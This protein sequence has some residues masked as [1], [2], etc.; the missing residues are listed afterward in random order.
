MKVRVAVAAA[1]AITAV[2]GA[3]GASAATA[4]KLVVDDEGDAQ[5][6]TTATPSNDSL[7]IVSADVAT[8][9]KSITTV[10]R[11]KKYAATDVVWAM[12]RTYYFNFRIPKYDNA[13]YLYAGTFPEGTEFGFGWLDESMTPSSLRTVGKATGVFDEA[14]SEIRV[15]AVL[16][17]FPKA[18][19]PAVPRGTKLSG[20]KPEA[21][22]YTGQNAVKRPDGLP[23][24]VPFYRGFVW[25]VDD[26]EGTKSY[27]AGTKSCV[28]VG[29]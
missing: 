2:F 28:A 7:D 4:C 12:G 24:S 1:L 22:G 19:L 25:V 15:T 18:Q 13:L 26:A 3:G 14:K 17:D 29:K 9:A 6:G 21:R 20:L 27:T 8:D 10:I 5:F 11:V 16:A 23:S